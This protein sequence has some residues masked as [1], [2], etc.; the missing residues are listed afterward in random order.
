MPVNAHNTSEHNQTIFSSAKN[1]SR[2]IYYDLDQNNTEIS[3][4][5]SNET[6]STLFRIKEKEPAA[7]LASFTETSATTTK[8]IDELKK[9]KKTSSKTHASLTQLAA[10]NKI[11][12]E[13]YPNK[14]V[15]SKPSE[16]LTASTPRIETSKRL[17]II[18]K[19]ESLLDSM[20]IEDV[21][22]LLTIKSSN[23]LKKS[24]TTEF[25]KPITSTKALTKEK[26][27]TRIKPAE[28]EAYITKYF[29]NKLFSKAK[30]TAIKETTTVQ[31]TTAS[32]P[33]TKV[34]S[35]TIDSK[36]QLKINPGNSP[37]NKTLLIIHFK[38]NTFH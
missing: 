3:S 10:L 38:K 34:I 12:V 6:N 32:N 27:A 16:G 13:Y 4:Y 24:Q 1:D 37:R 8:K 33:P 31:T 29:N 25:L 7:R 2:F 22:K 9:V 26:L 17:E 14:K 15:I 19:I 28:Y 23:S 35:T 11:T 21:L 20:D 5:F 30:S 18:Q 36:S